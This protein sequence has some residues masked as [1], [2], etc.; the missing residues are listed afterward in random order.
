MCKDKKFLSVILP[1]YNGERYLKL[2]IDSILSQTYQYFELIILNDGSTDGSERIIKSYNDSR[3]VYVKKDNSGLADTLNI[4]WRM[5][6]YDWIARMDA[7]DI[8]FPNRFE[9]QV[10]YLNDKIDIIGSAAVL[11]NEFGD[12]KGFIKLP[13]SKS[14]IIKKGKTPFVHPT[15]IIRKSILAKLGGYDTNLRRSE[16]L[17][18]WMRYFHIGDKVYNLQVPLLYY[19]LPS[20]TKTS[21][22]RVVEPIL[23]E[24][25][26]QQQFYKILSKQQYEEV[27]TWILTLWTYKLCFLVSKHMFKYKIGMKI[28]S[29]VWKICNYVNWHFIFSTKNI[30]KM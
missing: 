5:A 8:A 25:M 17:N 2:A 6:K 23:A 21:E 10:K 19:R 4:G 13:M 15:V 29:A 14:E 3:I 22:V 7:D 18:L 1:V 20:T 28:Y 11:I 12:E 30:L 27:Y 16:D 26:K 9:E 24:Y